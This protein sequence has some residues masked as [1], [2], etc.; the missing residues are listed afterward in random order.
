MSSFHYMQVVTPSSP[1]LLPPLLHL[2]THCPHHTSHIHA[3]KC[4][5]SIINKL[6][7]GNVMSVTKWAEILSNYFHQICH[8]ILVAVKQEWVMLVSDTYRTIFVIM[9][10]LT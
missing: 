6:P 7:Q 5:A 8:D 4:Y 3:T 2:S 10:I 9:V 1:L